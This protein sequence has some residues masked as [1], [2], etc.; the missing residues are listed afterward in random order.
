ML[1]VVLFV[2]VVILRHK[3]DDERVRVTEITEQLGEHKLEAAEKA[4]AEKLDCDRRLDLTNRADLVL[5]EVH[6][7]DRDPGALSTAAAETLCDAIGSHSP[8][9][10][11]T[12]LSG[13]S[14]WNK[15]SGRPELACRYVHVP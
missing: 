14:I 12:A 10:I 8:L 6:D 2:I 15:P 11:G 7:L 9:K 1:C 4:V 5:W 3:V 13:Y